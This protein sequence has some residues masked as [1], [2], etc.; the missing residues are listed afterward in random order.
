MRR[1]VAGGVLESDGGVDGG[2]IEA[3]AS[4]QVGDEPFF[5]AP[6]AAEGKVG[7]ERFGVQEL[8]EVAGGE[9]KGALGDVK[10]GLRAGIR[11]KGCLGVFYEETSAPGTYAGCDGAATKGGEEG[12][13]VGGGGRRR[14]QGFV[15]R[16]RA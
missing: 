5:E 11:T 9:G 8:V 4:F 1:F 10:I 6:K 7:G 13:G 3:Q 15:V 2:L 12:V 16:G 14:C